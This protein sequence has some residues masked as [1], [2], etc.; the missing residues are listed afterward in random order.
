MA[1]QRSF[2]DMGTPLAD[3]TFC[4]VDLETTGGS[5]AES[6][7]TE[8]GAIKVRRGEVVGTF[9]SL[10]DPG[11]P[12]PA[13][14]RLLTGISDELLI[15]A[16]PIETVLPSFL[17][18]L[19][20]SV[21]VA[22]NARFDVGF[23]NASLSRADYPRLD[24]R[25]VDTA[26]L[27]RK[28]LAGEVPN[29]KLSTLSTYLRCAHQPCHRAYEDVLATVDVLHHLIERA[30][31]FGVT[32]LE[33]LLALS[34]S[35]IDGTFEKIRLAEHLPHRPGIYRFLGAHGQ[36]LYV[37]KASDLKNRVRSYFYGDPRRKI[38]DLLRET[39]SVAYEQHATMLEAEVAEARAIAAELPPYNRAGKRSGSWYLK[40]SPAAG[41][42]VAPARVV[43]KD[44]SI[45]IGPFPSQR[46][47][48]DLIDALRDAA[49]IHRCS[50][51]SK[52]SGC[53]FSEMDRCVGQDRDE[54]RDTVQTLMRALRVNPDVV[55]APIAARMARL[56]KQARY[57]EAAEV[58]DRGA[59]LERTLARWIATHAL[60]GAGDIAFALGDR[61]LLVRDGVLVSAVGRS[62]D[63]RRTL[64]EL[65]E[66]ITEP[67]PSPRES[68]LIGSFLMREAGS[69]EVI[70]VENG[71]SWPIGAGPGGRFDAEPS[72]GGRRDEKIEGT[73]R[74]PRVDRRSRRR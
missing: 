7:I 51:P 11:Q 64:K 70:S 44:G 1:V 31:G 69:L 57:E 12:V 55:L 41:G 59:L 72:G 49:D 68:H 34:A 29:N 17:E 47:V 5:A 66:A 65:E 46:V 27:A 10:V 37:G 42:K 36:T 33:D 48:R 28:I 4:V 74:G 8:V 53:A 71:W 35:R 61:A 38:R 22:H 23:L 60:V 62:P 52:C 16:P 9:H 32:T 40:L 67:V 14:I 50:Q 18:F 13:F 26:T 54:H 30:A 2:E 15:E 39:Q 73:R 45:Y 3:V 21:V 24:N 43:K 56:G 6:A 25:V 20:D 63:P 58:R 19:R